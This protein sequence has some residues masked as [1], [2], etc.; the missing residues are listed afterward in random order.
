MKSFVWLVASVWLL[1]WTGA[2]LAD[3]QPPMPREL[4]T[5]PG[6]QPK[7]IAVI[8]TAIAVAFLLMGL[9][10]ARSFRRSSFFFVAIGGAILMLGLS[11]I[12]AFNAK[13]EWDE[14]LTAKGK[15]D[16][17]MANWHSRGPV[18][19]AWVYNDLPRAMIVIANAPQGGFPHG[20]PW[21][22]IV[23]SVNDQQRHQSDSS[24]ARP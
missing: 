23:L 22:A 16:R 9:Y 17:E 18:R 24:T 5:Y 11:A 13:E 19:P 1:A 20:V 12:A 6:T 3:V 8:G 15:Y 21:G 4:R 7:W 14:Y 2:A 10:L